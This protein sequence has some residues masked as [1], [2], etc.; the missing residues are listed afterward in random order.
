MDTTAFASAI[1]DQGLAVLAP[2]V[3]QLARPSI[4][5]TATSADENALAVGRS[6]LGGAPDMPIA[7]AW[8]L[9]GAAPMSFIAQIALDEAHATE[10]GA[11]LPAGGTLSFFYDASQQTFGSDPKDRAG[12]AVLYFPAGSSLWRTTPPGTLPVAA[13]FHPCALACSNETTFPLQP[14]LEIS[15]LAWGQQQQQQYDAALQAVTAKAPGHPQHRMLGRPDTIQDDMRLQCQLAANGVSDP[16]SAPDR[17]AQLTPGA[18][19][20]TLLLQ[21]DTDPAA[22]MNWG[23]NGMLYFWI[24]RDDLAHANFANCWVVLQ[25]E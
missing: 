1:H 6:R 16:S 14:N 4:R 12:F 2:L 7:Q 24:K 18:N 19:E 22:G 20:W 10:A 23:D 17:V 13:R 21:V 25:S 9:M 11:A 5:L 3:N 15:G 8:P